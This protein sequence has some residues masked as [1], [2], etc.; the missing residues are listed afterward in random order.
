MA[1]IKIYAD[2]TDASIHFDGSTVEP[3]PLG[4]VEASAIASEPNRI[5]IKRIEPKADGSERVF[6]KRFKA[7][8]VETQAGVALVNTSGFTTQQVID[9]LNVEFTKTLVLDVASYRGVWNATTNTPAL[10]D[11]T[12]ANGDFLYVTTAGTFETVDYAVNDTV[13]YNEG[14]TSWDKIE[15]QSAK[16]T[17]IEN[18]AK[19]D[20]DI[21]VD[22]D[23]TGASSGSILRPYSSIAD[24]ITNSVEGDRLF[25]KGINVVASEILLP[26]SLYFYGAELSEIKFASYNASN[27]N[28]FR[29]TGTDN[30]KSFTFKNIAFKNAGGYALYIQKA[31]KV[32]IENCTLLNNGWNGTGLNTVLAEAGGVLGHDSS[33][34]DLQ[35]FYAGANA[36]NGGAT[37]IEEVTQ[38]LI[39]GNTVKNNLRG[40]RV[41]DCGIY[42]GGFITRNQSSSNIESGIYLAVGSL[43]GCQNITTT[44]NVSAYNANNGLLVIGGIS[45]KFSQNE[46]SGNWNAGFCAWGSANSTLRDCGL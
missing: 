23:F 5:K 41:Q 10:A 9:Y 15:D 11:L 43:G 14:S 3:Q 8:R 42:G 12:P 37:R 39:I 28:I 25:I 1:N 6:F 18:S 31:A 21:Y 2:L 32:V 44:M 7:N 40:L 19:G 38:I 29:F 34:A 24:A 27:G 30:S 26:H 35:A 33:S 46:V 13:R 4:S 17:E 16:V 20:Y 45:N 22:A 36:S